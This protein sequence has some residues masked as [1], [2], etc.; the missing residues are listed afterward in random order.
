[1]NKP[2]EKT[3]EVYHS[4]LVGFLDVLEIRE[5]FVHNLLNARGG[6]PIMYYLNYEG[7]PSDEVVLDTY[8]KY[9]LLSPSC[10]IRSGITAAFSFGRAQ[11]GS[12]YWYAVDRDWGTYLTDRKSVV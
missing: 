9:V 6:T 1:M 8:V 4:L 5:V 7:T 2:I 11:R 10:S 3:H 12:D